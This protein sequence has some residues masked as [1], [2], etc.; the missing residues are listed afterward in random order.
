MQHLDNT[1][2]NGMVL[3]F[4]QEVQSRATQQDRIMTALDGTVVPVA[5]NGRIIFEQDLRFMLYRHWSLYEAMYNSN[6]IASRL[7]IWKSDG[8]GRL[9]E[10]L[11]QCGIPL[12][13]CKERYAFMRTAVK[14]RLVSM[15]KENAGEFFGDD[16][17]VFGTFIRQEGYSGSITSAA[18][19]AY[20]ITALLEAAH[21]D[22]NSTVQE[23]GV[24]GSSSS[25]DASSS[26]S[27]T[28]DP[29]R[30]REASESTLDKNFNEAYDALSIS[31]QSHGQHA[32]ALLKRGIE[33]SMSLQS[34]VMRQSV[35]IIENRRIVNAGPFRY[36]IYDARSSSFSFTFIFFYC[37][38]PY[39]YT[40]LDTLSDGDLRFFSYPMA[41]SKLALF[42][43]QAHRDMKKW[44][45]KSARPFL[46]A[47]LNAARTSYL[48]VGVNCPE[49]ES[50]SIGGERNNFGHAFLEAAEQIEVGLMPS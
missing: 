8:K 23:Q 20:S 38:C 37:Y 26:T 42:V 10:F 19:C 15:L 6:I 24:T 36:A 43:V 16:D 13:E 48:V 35:S 18:D 32:R 21:I 4:E 45:G 41:L 3:T 49:D 29:A 47:V 33:M 25:S 7:K 46:I 39:S 5:E 14:N 40:Y 28:T 1:T 9:N 2:Y 17:I 22:T 30:D 27:A 11:A 50:G 31:D 34:A 44:V 12:T